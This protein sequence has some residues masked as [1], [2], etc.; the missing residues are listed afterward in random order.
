M[1][2]VDNYKGVIHKAKK[3]FPH[4]SCNPLSKMVGLCSN[5][6]HNRKHKESL[7]RGFPADPHKI[8]SWNRDWNIS[9]CI[10]SSVTA[11]NTINNTYGGTVDQP[12]S[13]VCSISLSSTKTYNSWTNGVRNTQ[14][15]WIISPPETDT[16]QGFCILWA[17]SWFHCV[18]F[19]FF[20]HRREK[21]KKDRLIF[22]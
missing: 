21:K 17:G 9:V 12:V 19:V 16:R 13:P 1:V 5:P 15:R 14:I 6:G 8:K 4:A 20:L 7:P 11:I 3:R 10:C 2:K 22:D 18:P